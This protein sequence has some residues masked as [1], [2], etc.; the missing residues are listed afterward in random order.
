MVWY[1]SNVTE[2]FSDS[3]ASGI[4]ISQDPSEES[5]VQKGD[6]VNLVISKGAEVKITVVPDLN[7]LSLNEAERVLQNSNLKLGDT[8]EI[9]TNDK[10]QDGKIFSQTIAANTEVKQGSSVGV[11]YYKYKEPVKEQFDVPDFIGKTVKEAK[12]LAATI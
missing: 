7:G 12:D 5:L 9:V 1:L 3:I 11:S 10:S 6:K 8:K 2:E 4:V